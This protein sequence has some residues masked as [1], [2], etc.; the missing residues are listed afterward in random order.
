MGGQEAPNGVP[1]HVTLCIL[2]ILLSKMRYCIDSWPRASDEQS[3][4]IGAIRES[5]FAFGHTTQ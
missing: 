2:R 1:K 3:D 4:N 5:P